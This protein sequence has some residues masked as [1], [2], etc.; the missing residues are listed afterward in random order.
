ML[1]ANGDPTDDDLCG[2]VNVEVDE[3]DDIS[4]QDAIRY[5]RML[6]PHF[7]KLFPDPVGVRDF[8]MFGW[9]VYQ[10]DSKATERERGFSEGDIHFSIG[11]A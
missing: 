4:E 3:N 7:D 2:R 10:K 9:H 1:K 6:V 11:P 8:V 5:G